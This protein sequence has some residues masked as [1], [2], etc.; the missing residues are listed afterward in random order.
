MNTWEYTK[1]KHIDVNQAITS[2]REVFS[3]LRLNSAQIFRI[4][5][6][7]LESL[8]GIACL[9]LSRDSLAAPDVQSKQSLTIPS[10]VIQGELSVWLCTLK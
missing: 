4:A 6:L 8:L 10:S 2:M 5:D 9:I 1:Q 3:P 7:L